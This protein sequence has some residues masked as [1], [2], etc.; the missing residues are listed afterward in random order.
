M[1][2]TKN[3]RCE[4]CGKGLNRGSRQDSCAHCR[5]KAEAR[6]LQEQ[7]AINQASALWF[8]P[9]SLP[10][11]AICMTHMGGRDER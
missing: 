4:D 1:T 7:R 10:L 2:A 9:V 11:M 3:L 8:G 6:R 5:G